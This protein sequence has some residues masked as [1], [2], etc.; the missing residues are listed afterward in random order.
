MV[1]S[2]IVASP[3]PPP[4]P[5]GLA[6]SEQLPVAFARSC[7]ARHPFRTELSNEYFGHSRQ[8]CPSKASEEC[9]GNMAR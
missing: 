5:M 9:Y 6:F 7:L 1:P 3:S 2:R 8:S 4:P